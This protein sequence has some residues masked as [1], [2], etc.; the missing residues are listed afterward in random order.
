VIIAGEL[1]DKKTL[2]KF[3][4]LIEELILLSVNLIDEATE[5]EGYEED[6]DVDYWDNLEAKE[7]LKDLY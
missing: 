1:I 7:G 2:L 4:K 3:K 6:T 5:E